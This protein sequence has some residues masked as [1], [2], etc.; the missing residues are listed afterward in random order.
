MEEKYL[1]EITNRQRIEDTV[2]EFTLTTKGAYVLRDGKRYIVYREF[3][4]ENQ[5]EQTSTLKVDATGDHEI[6]SLIRNTPQH[7]R[8]NLVL[9][10]GKRHLCQYGTAFG[11]LTLGVFT[12]RI[13]DQLTDTGGTIEME[14]TLDVNTNLSSINAITIKIKEAGDDQPI[15]E[16]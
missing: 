11:C 16:A 8:T 10:Q 4:Q 6:V 14:Y 3:E 12:S 2:E 5:T 9:E 15:A 13:D 7:G 1:I